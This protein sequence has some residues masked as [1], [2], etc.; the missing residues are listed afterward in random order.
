MA[1]MSSAIEEQATDLLPSIRA[2]RLPLQLLSP[3]LKSKVTT[4]TPTFTWRAQRSD[5]LVEYRLLVAE[6]DGKII[7]DRWVGSDTVFAVPPDAPM[8][9]LK[10][11]HWLVQAQ[12]GKSSVKSPVWSFWIDKDLVTDLKIDSARIVN[13]NGQFQPGHVLEIQVQVQ[14]CGP[15]KIDQCFLTLFSGNTNRNYFDYSAYRKTVALDTLEINSL[16]LNE[17]QTFT[18]RGKIPPGLNPITIRLDPGFGFSEI[19]WPDNFYPVGKI[20]TIGE[21]VQLRGL[22]LIYQNYDDA[23]HRRQTLDE[24]DLEK[25]SRNI[26]RFQEYFWDHTRMVRLEVDTIQVNRLLT[27]ENFIYQNDAWGYVFPPTEAAK[28][29]RRR[30]IDP[31]SYDYV[32]AYYSWRNSRKTWTGYGGYTYGG[33]KFSSDLF[34]FLAQ[35]TIHGQ[36]ED[37]LITIHEFI[38]LLDHIFE[39]RGAKEFYSPHHKSLFTTFTQEIDYFEWMLETWPSEK[40]LLLNTGRR[41]SGQQN[42]SAVQAYSLAGHPETIAL[43][44]NYPNPF[45]QFTTF[46]FVIPERGSYVSGAAVTLTIYDLQGIRVRSFR[47]KYRTPGTFQISWDGRDSTNRHVATGIYFYELRVNDERQLKKLLIIH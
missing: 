13:N 29:L 10:L 5:S 38:H 47:E 15:E 4:T 27:T 43:M 46:T 21:N 18:L 33:Y 34:Y 22:F 6:P 9:D 28:D 17:P 42:Q 14:N 26:A 8:E 37:E 1:S 25:V 19:Y 23:E 39:R 7:I 12:R 32:F 36:V 40:W 44:Q 31:G 11:Y 35:P 16:E 30:G 41:N 2:D 45:N 24:D 3:K 20:Q